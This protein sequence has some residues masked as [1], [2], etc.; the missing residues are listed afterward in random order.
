[1]GL[2]SG[3]RP[4]PVPASPR[5]GT[6]APGPLPGPRLPPRSDLP[7][8]WAAGPVPTARDESARPQG[9]AAHVR[10][11]NPAGLSSAVVYVVRAEGRPGERRP[12]P[13]QTLT[14]EGRAGPGGTF[15]LRAEHTR[16]SLGGR[17]G[18]VTAGPAREEP[19]DAAIGTG[20]PPGRWL[21]SGRRPP[22]VFHPRCGCQLK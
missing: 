3:P 1:M 9:R 14:G 8:L 7:C 16:L 12:E 11:I 13:F 17:A 22:L 2:I 15:G 4:R 20:W 19:V 5:P 18:D 6:R 21:W 10:A